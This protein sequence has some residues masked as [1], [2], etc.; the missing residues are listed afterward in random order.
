MDN[1]EENKY[2]FAREI[3][4]NLRSTRAISDKVYLYWVDKLIEDEKI[5]KNTVDL[6]DVNKCTCKYDCKN[7]GDKNV[8]PVS[9][10]STCCPTCFC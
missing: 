4:F 7:C 8:K 10:G 3:I 5:S 2:H 6:A 9:M 1:T